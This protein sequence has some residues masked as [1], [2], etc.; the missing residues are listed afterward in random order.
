MCTICT[1]IYISLFICLEHVYPLNILV[2]ISFG[3]LASFLDDIILNCRNNQFNAFCF[4]LFIVT[5]LQTL[6]CKF[7]IWSLK[8]LTKNLNYIFRSA[9]RSFS[10]RSSGSPAPKSKRS[11]DLVSTRRITPQPH[12]FRDNFR[13]RSRPYRRPFY[14]RGNR[15]YNYFR[16]NNQRFYHNGQRGRFYN[17]YSRL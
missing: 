7:F 5:L 10:S 3:I 1:S 15:G 6:H 14:N 2:F 17:N 8:T 4:T 16:G 13:G 12:Y 11:L 9:S